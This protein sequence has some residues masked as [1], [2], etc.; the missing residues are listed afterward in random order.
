MLG[1]KGCLGRQVLLSGKDLFM[2]KR[3]RLLF[4]LA[5]VISLA[6]CETRNIYTCK[7]LQE[8]DGGASKISKPAG[9]RR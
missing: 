6:S 8:D 7:P 5:F 4:L 1:A 2:M 3:N 9:V